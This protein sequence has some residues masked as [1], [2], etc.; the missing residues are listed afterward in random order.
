MRKSTSESR[1]RWAKRVRLA[2]LVVAVLTVQTTMAADI[3][4]DEPHGGTF[5]VATNWSPQSVPDPN[6]TAIFDLGQTAAYSVTFS[7]GMN[8]TNS[9]CLVRDD[10]VALDLE[11]ITYTLSLA[12]R[13]LVVGESAGQVGSLWLTDGTIEAETA[14]VGLGEGA[15]GMLDF[16]PGITATLSDALGVANDGDGSVVIHDGASVTAFRSIIGGHNFGNQ[17]SVEVYGTDASLTLTDHFTVGDAGTATVLVRD[18]GSISS[19]HSNIGNGATGDGA[20]TVRGAEASF[21]LSGSL[22]VGMSGTAALT[23]ERAG[24]ASV[25]SIAR[26]AWFADSTGELTV[27]DPNSIFLLNGSLLVGDGGQ[28]QADVLNGGLIEAQEVNVGVSPTGEGTLTVDDASSEL[29]VANTM[30]VGQGGPGTATISNGATVSASGAGLVVGDQAT[31]TM[32]V[33]GGSSVQTEVVDLGCGTTGDGDLTVTGTDSMLDVGNAMNLG[34]NG[35]AELTVS[36]GGAVN[37]LNTIRLAWFEG[38]SGQLTVTDAES[39]LATDNLIYVGDGGQ[40]RADVLNGGSLDVREMNIG[41]STTGVG[42]LNVAD[43]PSVLTVD[44]LIRVGRYGPGTATISNGA[45]ISAIGAAM[46]IGDQATGTMTISGGSTAQAENVDLGYSATGDGEATITGADSLLDVGNT[47]NLGLSGTATL[48]VAD[49]G[50]VDVLNTIRIAWFDT[51]TADVTV[52]GAGS[53]LATDNYLNVGDGGQGTL[54]ILGGGA[55]SADWM[56]IGLAETADGTTSVANGG[57]RLDVTNSIEVGYQGSGALTASDGGAI[58]A[59]Q[60]VVGGNQIGVAEFSVSGDDSTATIGD[61]LTVGWDGQGTCTL[62]EGASVNAAWIYLGRGS[63]GSGD[64]SATGDSTSLMATNTIAVGVAGQAA[65]DVAGTASVAAQSLIIGWD[66]TGDGELTASGAGTVLSTTEGMQVGNQGIGSLTIQGQAAGVA[67]WLEAGVATTGHGDVIV[68]GA[69]STLT[70]TEGLRIGYWGT[71]ALEVGG[72]ATVSTLDYTGWI[73]VG[74]IAG[75]DGTVTVDGGSLLSADLAPIVVGNSGQGA[76]SILGGSE[77]YSNG[78]LFAGSQAGAVANI[79]VDGLGSKYESASAYPS[80]LGDAGSAT[81]SIANGGHFNA[82]S[83][84]FLGL[85][86]GSGGHVTLSGT[87][88]TFETPVLMV[89]R[90]GAA[91]IDVGDGR[92]AL[93]V[94]PNSVPAGELH[95]GPGAHLGG[96]G[97]I[98]GTVVN[99][100]GAVYPGGSINDDILTGTLNVQGDFK[101]QANGTLWIELGGTTAGDEYCVLDVTG[102]AILGGELAVV[103]VD[104]FVPGLGDGFAVVECGSRSGEFDQ[105]QLPTLPEGLYWRVAYAATGV[106]LEVIDQQYELGDLN[107]D[108]WVNNGDID[109][110]VM[111]ISDPDAYAANYPG[112]DINLGDINQD[113]FVNNGDID[114]FVELLAR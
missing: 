91:S 36:T 103:L 32:I 45:A 49:G 10:M 56:N 53:S 8:I 52:T 101:Q 98:T 85:Q 43:A 74:D 92:A 35:S 46:G 58:D 113:T 18:G 67:H 109:A 26:V 3:F 51:A 94:D 38:S 82:N 50:N 17:G 69:G 42:T 79:T 75:S 54:S 63:T 23:I 71:G 107:C 44:E 13:G 15:H 29:V 100:D 72:G 12:G 24:S 59:N 25:E 83:A 48:T 7:P 55:A 62:T 30:R 104:G 84:C 40:G 33:S 22:N 112:C 89:G 64:G 14:D 97:L 102:S 86:E 37:V 47:L 93:G 57:S 106:N 110:F 80:K 20:V 9:A 1:G 68:D 81:L 21:D 31:G 90:A 96:T 66:T 2:T 28:G 5:D 108:G 16:G 111:A 61:S 41:S 34:Q 88:S 27:T 114:A 77:A 70:T 87:G 39:S 60:I 19:V 76:L 95:L 4:W 11:G 65:L 73:I 78:E 6:D 105:T 99:G